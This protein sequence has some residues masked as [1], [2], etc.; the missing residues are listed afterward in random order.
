MNNSMRFLITDK[1]ALGI[2][3]FKPCLGVYANLGRD[4]LTY[5]SEWR[6]RITN[7]FSNRF[8]KNV[9]SNPKTYTAL[10]SEYQV[11]GDTSFFGN[12]NATRNISTPCDTPSL[13]SL[14]K[15]GFVTQLK[16]VSLAGRKSYMKSM[17]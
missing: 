17:M 11:Q 1:H 8:M 2:L 5:V 12:W 10:Y 9:T 3:G 4:W 13:E 14:F 15:R 7:E 16:K 6:A